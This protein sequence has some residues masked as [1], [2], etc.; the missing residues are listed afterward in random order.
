MLLINNIFFIFD[1]KIF[2]FKFF[3]F[4]E[5][6]SFFSE[7]SEFVEFSVFIISIFF[8]SKF[9]INFESVSEKYKIFSRIS[10]F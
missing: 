7:T 8:I 5:I 1:F 3:S 9:F 2:F 4:F 10:V 6:S